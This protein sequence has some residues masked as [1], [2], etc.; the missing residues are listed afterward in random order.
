[1]K[2]QKNKVKV[3]LGE[4]EQIASIECQECRQQATL[5]QAEAERQQDEAKALTVK[6]N[7]TGFMNALINSRGVP[8]QYA[9]C[10]FTNWEGEYPSI[11]PGII[12][13]KTGVGKTHLA[14]GFMKQWIAAHTPG[15]QDLKTKS[16]IIAALTETANH[17]IF[18]P[19][20]NL[21]WEMRSKAS[22]KGES[23][24]D[25]M[26]E[27]CG[28]DFAIVDDLGAERQTEWAVEVLT[29]LV[30]SRHAE[31]RHTLFTSNLVMSQIAETFGDRTASRILDFGKPYE[32][33]NV[34]DWRK[35]KS[36]KINE[37]EVDRF[38][39]DGDCDGV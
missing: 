20:I 8:H 10:S 15:L 17:A 37:R 14:V 1:M 22:Q 7:P 30:F 2:C 25:A 39:D 29:K 6:N 21:V 16:E 35:T 26:R 11:M 4:N 31:E 13:G 27:Y 9:R 12:I 38:L 23:I 18:I 19:A 5:I 33:T 34:K 28:Y 24:D 3:F 32:I 36:L